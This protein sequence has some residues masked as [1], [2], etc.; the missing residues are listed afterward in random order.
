MHQDGRTM[1]LRMKL[2]ALAVSLAVIGFATACGGGDGDTAAPDSSPNAMSA[3]NECMKKEGIELPTA[4]P[5]GGPRGTI[6]TRPSGAPGARPSGGPGGGSGGLQ[7]PEGVDQ[8]K[9][10][11]AMQVCGSLRPSRSPGGDRIGGNAFS[12]YINC[13]AERG[14]TFSP[15]QPIATTDPKVADAVKV[16]EVLRPTGSPAP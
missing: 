6:G 13:L 1:L 14:I 11:S 5:S 4:R 8:E 9:W 15:G 10:A 2:L 3:F 12:A 7:P 16:C